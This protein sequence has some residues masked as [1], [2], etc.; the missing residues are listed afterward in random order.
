MDENANVIDGGLGALLPSQPIPSPELPTSTPYNFEELQRGSSLDFV[1][2]ENEAINSL[3]KSAA[4][5]FDPNSIV[6]P[7]RWEDES[8]EKLQQTFDNADRGYRFQELGFLPNRPN[9]DY[10]AKSLT[11]WEKIGLAW[12]QMGALAKETFAEQWNTE[13]DFWGNLATGKIKDAFAPFGDEDELAAMYK[14][15]QDVTTKNYIPLTLEERS[16]E[17]GFGKFAT[18]LGQFG[19]TL[20]TMGAFATQLGVEFV[21]A[22]LLVPETAGGSALGFGAS[23]ANKAKRLFTLG[24][25]YS[26]LSALENTAQ[27]ANKLRRVYESLSTVN[28]LKSNFG[29]FY[30]FSKM[31]NAAAGEAKFE[32]AFSY[33]EYIESAK[34]KAREENRILTLDELN[35]VED[36]AMKVAMNNGITNT[37]L[38]FAMNKLNMNNFF[39]GP[40]NPQRR[41]L[42]ELASNIEQD[43][44]TVGGKTVSRFEVPLFSKQGLKQKAISLGKWTMSSGWEGV[45]EVA[46]GASA[47]YWDTW[48]K[49]KYDDK[50]AYEKLALVGKTIDK[51]LSDSQ[52]FEEFISGFIIG[53]PGSA[54]NSLVGYGTGL[55]NRKQVEGYKK[56]LVDY[57]KLINEYENDPLR[58]FDPRKAN[59]NT[60]ASLTEQ[61]D[62]AVRNN[63]IYAYKNLQK[64]QMRDMI[65]LGIRTGKLN[66]MIGNM[67]D[68]IANMSDEEF[69]QQFGMVSDSTNRKKAMDYVG[70]F[71]KESNTIVQEY[72]KRK[73]QLPNPYGNTKGLKKGSQEEVVQLIKYQAWEDAVQDLV[74]ENSNYRDTLARMKNILGD[75]KEYIGDALYNTY[76]MMTSDEAVDREIQLLNAEITADKNAETQTKE[77]RDRISQK[78]RRVE[79]LEKWRKAYTA[80]TRP[81]GFGEAEEILQRNQESM[82]AFAEVLNLYQ[83]EQEGAVPL[84]KDNIMKAYEGMLDFFKLRKDN[85]T[86]VKNLS[87]LA[88]PE[89][90]EENFSARS[91]KAEQF[92][93]KVLELR[94]K[95]VEKNQD[96][97]FALENDDQFNSNPIVQELK[98]HLNDAMINREYDD[99]YSIMQMLRQV[100]ETGKLTTEEERNDQTDLTPV[101]IIET[102]EG[103]YLIIHN[104]VSYQVFKDEPDLFFYEESDETLQPIEKKDVPKEVI[105][106]LADYISKKPGAPAPAGLQPVAAL[107]P[108]QEILNDIN[109]ATDIDALNKYLNNVDF[110]KA[111]YSEL[112]EAEQ[113]LIVETY[114]NRVDALNK[115]AADAAKRKQFGTRKES[116]PDFIEEYNNAMVNVRKVVNTP[117]VT[118]TEVRAAFNAVGPIINTLADKDVRNQ[119]VRNLMAQ[120]DEIIDQIRKI[121]QTKDIG[122][123]KANIKAAFETTP[124]LTEAI[125]SVILIIQNSTD[126]SLKDEAIAY[127]DEEFKKRLDDKIKVLKS[128]AGEGTSS[129]IIRKYAE[130]TVKFRDSV[131]SSLQELEKLSADI[132]EE[133]AQK[134]Y[135]LAVDV[136][137]KFTNPT[138]RSIIEKTPETVSSTLAQRA[139]IRNLIAAGIL[140]DENLSQEDDLFRVGASNLINKGVARIYTIGINKEIHRYFTLGQKDRKDALVKVIADYIKDRDDYDTDKEALDSAQTLIQ[141]ADDGNFKGDDILFTLKIP[142]TSIISDEHKE[143]LDKQR[144][145]ISDLLRN[146]S[147]LD[148]ITTLDEQQ[149]ALLAS[150][151]AEVNVTDLLTKEMVKKIAKIAKKDAN[152]SELQSDVTDFVELL[153]KETDAKLVNRALNNLVAKYASGARNVSVFKNVITAISSYTLETQN[154]V[155]NNE[156]SLEPLNEDEMYGVLSGNQ[157]ALNLSQITQIEEFALNTVLPE[158]KSKFNAVSGYQRQSVDFDPNLLS[159]PSDIKVK[160]SILR[161]KSAADI[162]ELAEL[163]TLYNVTDGTIN[164]QLALQNIMNSEFATDT[165]KELAYKLM[166]ALPATAVMQV[167]NDLKDLG[168]YDNVTDTITINLSAAAYNENQPTYAIETLILHELMH[169]IIEEDA[170]NVNSTF[171]KGIKSVIAAVKNNPA[172]NTFYAFQATLSED[173]QVREFAIEALTNPA[174]QYFLSKIEYGKTNKSVW[175]KFIDLVNKLLENLGVRMENSALEETLSLFSDLVSFKTSETY[176]DRV[177]KANIEE[178]PAL[179]EEIENDTT[180]QPTIKDGLI[181]TINRKINDYS[182]AKG[183]EVVKSMNKFK[184]K[185]GKTYYYKFENGRLTVLSLNKK[186]LVKVRKQD[187]IDEIVTSEIKSGG[188]RKVLSDSAIVN[189]LKELGDP[190]KPGT[191]AS[192]MMLDDGEGYAD[193]RFPNAMETKITLRFN[194]KDDYRR[195]RIDYV[196]AIK[197]GNGKL[198][199]G[200]FDTLADKYGTTAVRDYTELINVLG[201]AIS[202]DRLIKAKQIYVGGKGYSLEDATYDTELSETELFDFYEYVLDGGNLDLSEI[203]IVKDK[204][205]NLLSTALGVKISPELQSDIE[206]MLLK[207]EQPDETAEDTFEPKPD[208]DLVV[209]SNLSKNALEDAS[210]YA[211]DQDDIT[212]TNTAIERNPLRS[213]N[214]DG[215]TDF[216][217]GVFV[218]YDSY[219]KT[220]FKVREIMNMLSVMNEDQLAG[221]RVT[222]DKDNANLRWDGS[223]ETLTTDPSK[224]GVLGYISD[225]FGNPIIFNKKGERVGVLD[226]AN[227][228]DKKGLDDGENQIIYFN[229]MADPS[230]PAVKAAKKANPEA[231]EELMEIRRK[232]MAGTPQIASI[233]RIT[234]GQ[235]NKKA[236]VNATNKTRQD[237][238][239]VEFYEQLDQPHVSLMISKTGYLNAV[240]KAPNGAVNRFALFPPKTR[241]ISVK[242]DT[243]T[244]SLA[245]YLIEVMRLYKELEL[246]GDKSA[247]KIQNDLVTFVYNMWLTGQNQK[248]QIP[249]KLDKIGIKEIFKDKFD[250][251]AESL[252]YYQIFSIVDGQVVPDQKNIDHVKAY[253]NNLPINVWK[254]W[255]TGEVAFKFP[256]ITIDQQGRKSLVLVNKNYKDFLFKEVGLKS[257]VTEIPLQ[258]YIKSYNSMVHFTNTVPL[259]IQGLPTSVPT[260][261]DLIDNPNAIQDSLKDKDV[262]TEIDDEELEI[263]RKRKRFKVPGYSAIFEKICR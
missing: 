173:D 227:L 222:I 246:S 247:I 114:T 257:N 79:K 245:D 138:H 13:A 234:Q 86:A 205:N 251:E 69:S 260:Q 28:G 126:P 78:T 141:T 77:I 202:I 6:Q 135:S 117:A 67:R 259:S 239:N 170:S 253:L 10:F 1:Q 123:I 152:M 191:Y 107:T 194:T 63:D 182:L 41:Y 213:F 27:T 189:I 51:H 119:Y 17:Y 96:V 26:K 181:S 224:L 81:E 53:M 229:L 198:Q 33:G 112:T 60:Q 162:R 122:L 200:D 238:R 84:T 153:K 167:D 184:A 208:A 252:F 93:A 31:Y 57:A 54:V 128:V 187:V 233:S 14:T 263:L 261:Q 20:G 140:T 216:K 29:R 134:N 105:D 23:L 258:D 52:A 161:P 232:V 56:Q 203:D 100:Y 212:E 48:Y 207:M 237:T 159:T 139:A 91:L 168:I 164:V 75:S 169:K 110:T 225:E 5:N 22:A 211:F 124:S 121:N 150:N 42:T 166:K 177:S 4:R 120:R 248:V 172:A 118:E 132:A 175:D 201:D 163:T 47:K 133:S 65:M 158:A 12:D 188:L 154:A 72:D 94:Q 137:L 197:R 218:E 262:K 102:P 68:M 18:G 226:K 145:V 215:Y 37:G 223:A 125:E 196:N 193:K 115:A 241:Y 92:Y 240:I 130:D 95:E 89:G 242:S 46:Q 116:D 98:R 74:F 228:A 25:F 34:Q 44:V 185:D 58:V 71:E 45:Q 214:P 66:Y 209:S 195:F 3:R 87:F 220:Y 39:R 32:A 62:E 16:G 73:Q 85:E 106:A 174:F 221:L 157:V 156:T 165:E 36:E 192:G 97:L 21:A 149:K 147:L 255:L 19:F 104:G 61:M 40:F 90:F 176:L 199:R 236:L 144:K 24:S 109:N 8:Y 143:L 186:G 43:L 231:F 219:K 206:G 190:K 254:K 250:R 129:E 146:G 99:V 217:T 83:E 103:D 70:A 7:I 108:L 55:V 210:A 50:G 204:I 88:S 15:M 230:K 80:M 111:P 151:P 2:R 76:Y 155:E 11:K 30:S 256:K 59:L 49:E 35:K 101:N 179:L 244:Y 183:T 243:E 82:D 136:D 235:M 160:F 38:L 64:E 127:F 131:I 249:K 113:D 142:T 148:I 180:I 9:E 178:L 171:Y